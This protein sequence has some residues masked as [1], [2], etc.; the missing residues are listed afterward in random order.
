[1]LGTFL[2]INLKSKSSGPKLLAIGMLLFAVGYGGMG[3]SASFVITAVFLVI[4]SFG[5]GL[6]LP[7]MLTWVMG[8]LPQNVRGR[9]TG[10]WTGMF[11]LGQFVAPLVAVSLTQAFDGLANVLL[12]YGALAGV[13]MLYAA[14]RSRGAPALAQN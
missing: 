13:F 11:F 1:M 5:A 3:L 10:L 12:A 6:L 2:F 9:G 7:T 4:S 8:V 14:L